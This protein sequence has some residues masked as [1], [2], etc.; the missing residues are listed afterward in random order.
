LTH[1]GFPDYN[2]VS[3]SQLNLHFTI[4]IMKTK[5]VSR[6][7]FSRAVFVPLLVL[8]ATLASMNSL[9]V[10]A[11]D[12]DEVSSQSS[13]PNAPQFDY[14]HNRAEWEW[15]MERSYP[16][17]TPLDGPTLS[18]RQQEAVAQ[19]ERLQREAP[20]PRPPLTWTNI[21]PIHVTS[22]STTCWYAA[23]N[24]GRI[25]S[26]AIDPT[27]QS[28]W[29]IA[30]AD[31]GIWQTTDAGGTWSPRTDNQSSLNGAAIAFAPGSPNI[32]YASAPMTGLLKSTDGGSTWTVIEANLFSGRS[33]RA[34]VVSPNDWK[35][36][37]VA[38]QTSFFADAAYGIYLTKDGGTTWTQKLQQS[39]SALV[40]VPGDFTRQYAAIGQ[41]GGGAN[42][43][44]YRSMDSG[45]SWQ[46]ISGPW[47]TGSN[48]AQFQLALSPSQ[49]AVL[50]VSVQVYDQPNNRWLGRIWESTNAWDPTPSF[51][52]SPLPY[53]DP[54]FP[55]KFG[56][57]L[58]VD[59]NNPSD[60]YEGE[61]HLWKYHNGQWTDITG[62]PP[63]GTHVDTWELKWIP[64]QLTYDLVVTNDGGIFRSSNHGATYQ[65]KNANL[66]ITQFYWGALHPTNASFALAG[67]QD[68]ASTKWTGN[69]IWPQV[70]G[71]TGDGMSNV[72]SAVDPNNDWIVTGWG[73]TIYRTT[74][75]GSNWQGSGIGGAPFY[76]RVVGCSSADVL[77]AG[78]TKL[79]RSDNAFTGS[80]PTWTNNG[81]DLGAGNSVRAI[82]F[83]PSGACGTY[84]FAGGSQIRATTNNGTSWLNLNLG[85]P[86]LPSATVMDL[87]FDP[88]NAL[89]LFATFSGID[90][91]HL[92]V[93]DNITLNPPVWTEKPTGLNISHNAIAIDPNHASDLY[94]GT[95]VGLIISTDGGTS[96]APIG[97]G[98]IP[99][100]QI[101]D[102]LIN[103]AYNKIL[104]F[105][106][107]RGTYSGDL[108]ASGPLRVPINW[109]RGPL[110][111]ERVQSKAGLVD[112]WFGITTFFERWWP[113]NR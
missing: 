33:A 31:G 50:Y 89:R 42:N 3:P 93:C 53:P 16:S 74:N 86:P 111:S 56:H 107:G 54:A 5:S 88:T 37:V 60:L 78:T 22:T 95:D 97:S 11:S 70:Q 34:F 100:V 69:S 80:Q 106:Y 58:S 44:L 55:T 27:N 96:W 104:V 92:F 71:N 45:L 1:Y 99:K 46:P 83:A 112:R 2:G 52:P 51:G 18:K 66:P 75:A 101:N 108:P 41:G 30:G 19:L 84:A 9:A 94:V 21:G 23:E 40:S 36:A 35:T 26:L 57:A 91:G 82:E 87:A 76:F 79:L 65:S 113:H 47:G 98:L 4:S 28:H 29:L 68:Q 15:L 81:P 63:S 24:S 32:V 12:P 103:R 49:P 67:A 13:D 59:P 8:G 38:L 85:N 73:G 48:V 17:K 102:I 39:A 25:V 90:H 43:G 20:Q 61:T 110:N 7:F 64:T 62:C 109:Q 14:I 77:L 6:S 105:T 72:I 10:A